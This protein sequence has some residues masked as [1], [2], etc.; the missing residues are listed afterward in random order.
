VKNS[1]SESVAA[2]IVVTMMMAEKLKPARLNPPPEIIP[3]GKS[4]NESVSRFISVAATV[5]A[6]SIV[7]VTAVIID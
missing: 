4:S 7:I 2:Q 6:L 1:R 5:G 3:P